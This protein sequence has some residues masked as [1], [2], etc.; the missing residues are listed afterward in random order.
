MTSIEDVIAGI[1]RDMDG[2]GLELAARIRSELPEYSVVPVEESRQ[3]IV[4]EYRDL[5][6]AV[7][8]RRPPNPAESAHSRMIGRRRAE[9]GVPV[10][11]LLA[12]YHFGLRM[13]WDELLA[14]STAS[15]PD[16]LTDLLTVVNSLWDA[17]RSVSTA[18][19]EGHEA[20]AAGRRTSQVAVVRSL[21][22]GLLS[23]RPGDEAVVA[24]ARALGFDADGKFQVICCPAAGWPPDRL[25]DLQDRLLR[26]HTAVAAPLGAT[27]FLVTQNVPEAEMTRQLG[28][29]PVA[30]F[31]LV[32]PGLG[33]A[34][35]SLTDAERALA[36][37]ERRKDIVRF[38]ESWLHATVL[39]QLP[40]LAELLDAG[41]AAGQPHLAEAVLAYAGNG[42]SITAGSRALHIHPNKLK[43]RL[44]RWQDLTG[45]DPRTLN[46]LL[47]S[48]LS[49]PFGP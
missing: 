26:R 44:N 10:E 16:R 20:A 35:E 45:W 21:L 38:E 13:V 34:A 19:V 9:Q 14:R 15:A 12:S 11:A 46:G 32:R 3:M 25:N 22:T 47:R 30:G 43:Y 33:G 17:L 31:G 7:M 48:I 1:A 28:D 8:E 41:P 2:I 24:A 23:S 42:F 6:A 40:R 29:R 4:Q 27:I 36:L 37:A 5:L 49:L 39:P 18:A